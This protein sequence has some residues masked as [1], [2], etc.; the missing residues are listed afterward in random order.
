MSDP[1]FDEDVD[2]IVGEFLVE[3]HENLDQL[4]RDLVQ[5]ERDPSDRQ[6]LAS[7]FRTIHTIKGTSGFLGFGRLEALTHVGESL[8]SRLRDGKLALDAEMTSALLAMVDAIRSILASIE[9][10]GEEG[11][12]DDQD[13]IETLT[14][15]QEPSP[16]GAAPIGELLV[17]TTNAQ[18]ADV[19]KA[20]DA[21]QAG[22]PRHVGEILVA[23]GVV[24]PH[25]V[26]DA[27]MV[28]AQAESSGGGL[29]DASIRVDVALLD[30]LMVLAGELVL[31]RNQI[32]QLGAQGDDNSFM[33]TSQRLNLITT[34]LQEGIM[35]TRMQPIGNVWAKFPRVVRD[36][37]V[38][39]HKQVRIEFDG[40]ETELD[41]TIIEAIKDPL[42]HLLRN[43][44]D[45]GIEAPSVRLEKGKP[46]E[47]CVRL[48]AFHEGGHVNIEI[49]DDGAGLDLEQIQAKALAKGLIRPE[50]VNSLSEREITNLIFLPGF[51]TAE[52]VT[53]V[54]G[55]G[56][57]M[58]VVRTNIEKIG[59]TIDVVTQLGAGT[60]FKLKIPLTLAIIPALIVTSGGQRYA[61]PQVS[62]LELVRLDPETLR[63]SIE[64]VGDAPVH[65]LRGRL[66]P[67]VDLSDQLG[68]GMR[69]PPRAHSDTAE[70]VQESMLTL[71]VLQS[72]GQEFGLV[73]ESVSDTEE[74]VVK[75]LARQLKA[76]GVYSGAA[77]MG[78]GRV[79]LILDVRGVAQRAHVLAGAGEVDSGQADSDSTGAGDRQ[80]VL[81]I[82]V[83][84]RSRAAVPLTLVDRLEEIPA[85]T[86]EMAGDGEVVQ[87]R[88][89]I[90]AIVRLGNL[91]GQGGPKT[92]ESIDSELLNVIV[93]RSNGRIIGL[94][95]DRVVD[96]V[97]D[98]F[99]L[100]RSSSKPGLLG[101][102][103]IDG[104]VTDIVDLTTIVGS[105]NSS[106]STETLGSA[107]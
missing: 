30:K 47:G 54:S 91:L 78:D 72:D 38:A 34:E 106:A 84:P 87:Y 33:A 101:S 14:R 49:S 70:P 5:L 62:L 12:R 1:G 59:G 69:I 41:R 3:S 39:C 25:E 80:S 100:D 18:P 102:A 107:S 51:S 99:E 93:H 26:A 10:S 96:I 4:D 48:R 105:L 8:L 83:G 66:L 27:L 94:V 95:V 73:V 15:L 36:L 86:L 9:S 104:R 31:A 74:I 82:G 13:L 22:D 45:H 24:E 37:S 88:G 77:I 11:E 50:S 43:A 81:I 61:I 21:Q 63:T 56:V 58:D 20:L 53:N 2:E 19:E 57:G 64:Y 46:P 55:R 42:T 35:K 7:I 98:H 40:R 23:Q 6:C 17:A 28:Q 92:I 67:L 90:M 52:V 65:R 44:V 89:G 103:I 16:S 60:T 32:M 79:A 76:T 97:D 85:S 71:V 75:P 68:I 29:S